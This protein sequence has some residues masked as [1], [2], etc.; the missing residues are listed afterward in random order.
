MEELEGQS[1]PSLAEKIE[2][3]NRLHGKRKK[4][5]EQAIDLILDDSVSRL[6]TSIEHFNRRVGTTN[7][8]VKH[9]F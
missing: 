1:T 5:R 2:E 4:E 3:L 9:I 7:D 6:R 8:E